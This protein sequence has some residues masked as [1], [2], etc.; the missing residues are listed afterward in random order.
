MEATVRASAEDASS[1]N[2]G[3]DVSRQEERNAKDRRLMEREK[4]KQP[5]LAPPPHVSCM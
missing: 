1:R 3:S 2:S 5:H 4:A